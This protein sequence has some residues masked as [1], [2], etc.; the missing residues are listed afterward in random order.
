[1]NRREFL[2]MAASLPLLG[3]LPTQKVIAK[4][5]ANPQILVLVRLA[6]GNDGLN[7]LI[8]HTD[9]L[10]YQY[11]PSI[12]I[13]KHQVL[14]IGQGQGM[15]PYLKAL[16]PY[17]ETGEMAWV[18][19][20]GYPHYD[21]SHFRAN[22]IWETGVD[23]AQ[24]ADS[25]WLGRV[26]P[27]YKEGLHGI[28]LGD[29]TGPLA[30]KDCCTLA[31]QSPQMFLSQ[32]DLLEDVQPSNANPALLHLTHV[33]HQLYTAGRQL[34]QKLQHPPALGGSFSSSEIGR[35]LESVAKIVLS[36]VDAAAYLVTLD[37]FDTHSNQ[38]NTQNNLLHHLAG[39]LDS[40][41][42]A[43]KRAG[44]WDDVLVVT[45]SEFGRR[46]Q[47]NHAKGTDHGAAS[48]QLV[49]GGKVRGGV[50]GDRPPLGELDYDGNL[51]YT[52]DFRSVYGTLVQSLWGQQNPWTK[53]GTLAFV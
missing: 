24:Y 5:R 3:L 52:V 20:V 10:Y 12:A 35:D 22:D 46:V 44:R 32:L 34:E 25:G 42:Q 29:S 49:M 4:A 6:G 39:G 30:G 45:Y 48:V 17:W 40:F 1:M 21:M 28:I 51:N 50:H 36:G 2:G 26:L 53:L 18:Q 38:L 37:G 16:L 31:M 47:E 8:P 19:G 23:A 43:M 33:Q 13:P 15:N 41:A 11:R 14:D 7:T 27:N 9:P